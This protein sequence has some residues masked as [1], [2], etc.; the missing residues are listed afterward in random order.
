MET[1]EEYIDRESKHEKTTN[2]KIKGKVVSRIYM[3]YEDCACIE[4]TDSTSLDVM[5]HDSVWYEVNE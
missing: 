4:F 1:A 3:K 2:E 5:G